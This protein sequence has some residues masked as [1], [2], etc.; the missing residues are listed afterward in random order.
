MIELENRKIRFFGI[1][2]FFRHFRQGQDLSRKAEGFGGGE[3]PIWSA[4]MGGEGGSK[5]LKSLRSLRSFAIAKAGQGRKP[6]ALPWCCIGIALDLF[7]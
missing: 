7:K 1:F 5:S 6:L 3:P 4:L 2:R